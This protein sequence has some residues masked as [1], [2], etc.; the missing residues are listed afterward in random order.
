MRRVSGPAQNK[1][2]YLRSY[3]GQDLDALYALDLLCF[4][5]RFRFSREMMHTVV[6]ATDALARLACKSGTDGVEEIVGFCVVSV[7]SFAGAPVGYVATLDVSPEHRGQGIGRALMLALEGEVAKAR[8]CWMAL[9]VYVGNSAALHLYE[10]L[11]Y[12]Q[13]QRERGFYGAGFDAWFYR[14]QLGQR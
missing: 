10:K 5:P 4:E 3:E 2:M 9:H 14:K 13:I 6:S 7:D 11:G 12:S 8:V 1:G